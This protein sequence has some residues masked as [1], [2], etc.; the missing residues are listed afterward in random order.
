M[1]AARI[2]RLARN[3]RDP[4]VRVGPDPRREGIS[5]GGHARESDGPIVAMKL[6]KPSRAKG[7]CREASN[8]IEKENRLGE[9]PTTEEPTEYERPPEWVD[10]RAL[11][12]KVSLLRRKLYA[13]A[14]KEPKF[15]FYALYDRI[16]RPDVLTAAWSQVRA[17]GGAPGVDGMTIDD[18][19]RLDGGP[20]ALVDALHEELR[21][22][23]YRPSAVRRVYI[24]KSN[25]K[26]RPLGIPTVRDRVVQTAALLVLEP[27]F[28][29]DFLDC[30]YGFRPRRRAH[31]AL[32][33]IRTHLQAGFTEVYDADLKGY[34]DSIPHDKLLRAV[35][36]RVVDRSVLHLLRLWLGAPVTDERDGGPPRPSTKGTPQGGVISPLL[37][38][39]FLHWFD[40]FFHGV[41]GPA[42]WANARLVRYADDFVVLARYQ[43]RRL[44]EWLE[45][46][47]EARLGL[48]L[49]REKTKIV[50]LNE[51][52]AF[53]FLGFTFTRSPSLYG[54][55]DYLSVEPSKKALVRE[56]DALRGIVTRHVGLLPL[57][58]LIRRLN[59]HLIGWA[60]YFSFGHPGRAFRR[61]NHHVMVR[62]YGHLK[63]R[64][65]RRYRPPA[66]KTIY[67]HLLDLGLVVL[68]RA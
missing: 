5:G 39:I 20:A 43:G 46:T 55:G 62:L 28:E 51:N 14:K 50:K 26:E 33:E 54:S 8:R 27:I 9:R 40:V 23:T 12:E 41:Q 10:R 1:G 60:N 29:A 66:G 57:P 16:Y 7:P 58:V 15:R 64:S 49:N 31:D 52:G 11:P 61:I 21:T 35:E 13:K 17:N 53:D 38:N 37:A 3:L 25:G 68:Q 22:Q 4:S 44:R 56:G 45:S 18:V 42:N 59:R 65:Q 2:E 48:E 36:M 30:S 32:A 67:R 24:P 19:E 63:R 6:G 47:L 34:F